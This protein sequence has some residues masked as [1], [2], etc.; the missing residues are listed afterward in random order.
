[1]VVGIAA[2]LAAA[3]EVGPAFL[4]IPGVASDF[5]GGAYKG[6]ISI[7]ASDWDDSSI[8]KTALTASADPVFFSGP[9]ASRQGAGRLVIAIN[10]R[11]AAAAQLMK[12][13][14]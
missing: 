13:C 14:V 9:F 6:W 2:V 4:S 1:V 3:A 7:E 12:Q 5:P 10:T 11:S 8:K